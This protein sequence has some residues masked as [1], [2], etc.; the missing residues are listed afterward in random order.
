[1]RIENTMVTGWGKP[2][3]VRMYAKGIFED[4]TPDPV[5]RCGRCKDTLMRDTIVYEWGNDWLCED[6]MNDAVMSLDPK[7]WAEM[8]GESV[9]YTK[10]MVEMARTYEDLAELM[11]IEKSVAWRE[12]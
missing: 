5:Y 3:E 2:D 9:A 8:T 4:Y 6:C 1:M 11:H 12:L 10:Q 7:D